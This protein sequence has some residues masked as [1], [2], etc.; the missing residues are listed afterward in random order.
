[1]TDLT[2]LQRFEREVSDGDPLQGVERGA[3]ERALHDAVR[4]ARAAHPAIKVPPERF[5]SFIAERV[6]PGDGHALVRQ[7]DSLEVADLYLACGCLVGDDAAGARFV[8]RCGGAVAGVLRGL[9]QPDARRDEVLSLVFERLFVGS[10]PK[11]VHYR[12]EGQLSAWVKVVS[13]RLLLNQLRKAGREKLDADA[14]LD[15]ALDD[16]N[17]PA[18]LQYMKGMYRREFRAAF[19]RAVESLLP[20]QRNILRYQ[21]LDAMSAQQIAKI[22]RVHR[23]TVHRWQ[24]EIEGALFDRTRDHLQRQLDIGE[25]ELDSIVRLI[26]SSWQITV[27]GLLRAAAGG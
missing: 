14:L 1:M 4:R 2:L 12:G 11:I 19:A 24:K 5:V 17:E 9:R 27:S 7:L 10:S 15:R 13:V 25:D 8:E 21:L 26:Q 23:G 18:D 20:K 22:Y 6:R 3:L 16:G